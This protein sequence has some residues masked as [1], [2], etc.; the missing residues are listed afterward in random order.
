MMVHQRCLHHKLFENS[1]FPVQIW[2][3]PAREERACMDE[4]AQVMWKYGLTP[5]RC[6]HN[7]RLFVDRSD[8]DHPG[9]LCYVSFNT[10]KN[11]APKIPLQ[12]SS[13]QSSWKSSKDATSYGYIITNCRNN[14]MMNSI[15]GNLD[16]ST[17]TSINLKRFNRG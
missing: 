7:H 14:W 10:G 5:F 16:K 4:W 15:W 3:M 13:L 17:T 8:V 12:Y 11:S 2:D 9:W 6:V 1:A